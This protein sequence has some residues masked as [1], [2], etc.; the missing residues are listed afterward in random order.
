MAL[1]RALQRLRPLQERVGL[2]LQAS[3]LRFQFPRRVRG[4]AGQGAAKASLWAQYNALLA[5][6]PVRTKMVTSGV[7]AMLGDAGCQLL[8]EDEG[9]SVRRQLELGAMGFLLRGPAL[10]AWYGF[11]SRAVTGTGALAVAKR[12]LLDQLVF[13][14]IIV[15]CI[16]SF[17]A[18]AQGQA[19]DIPRRMQEQ[20]PGAVLNNWKVWPAA[21][22]L[23]FALVPVQHQVL[24][25]NLVSVG[26]NGYLSWSANQERARGAALEAMRSVEGAASPAGKQ[27]D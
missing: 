2:P 11:L 6:H 26:W 19:G 5:T 24:F 4:F 12:I 10:H 27:G 1:S 20:V 22:C 9:F 3:R 15:S 14:P 23:N 18:V 16:L 25:S 8:F 7:I 13:A 17:L 21:Q